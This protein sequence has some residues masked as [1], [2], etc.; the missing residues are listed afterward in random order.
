SVNFDLIYG[1]PLQTLSSIIDTIEKVKLLNPDRIAFY[2][3][4][5]IPWTKPGQRKFTESD[6][7]EDEAKRALYETGRTMLEEAGYKEIGMD[8]FALPSDSLYKALTDGTL[9]RNFM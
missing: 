4:A 7:P 9:H 2:S 1:L 8:H 6:L 3:Y 5:H